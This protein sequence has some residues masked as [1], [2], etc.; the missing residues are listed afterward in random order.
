MDALYYTCPNYAHAV[1]FS[2]FRELGE[3]N[4]SRTDSFYQTIDAI[5]PMLEPRSTST[6]EWISFEKIFTMAGLC[7]TF[8]SLN[9]RDIYSDA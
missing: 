7:Y 6:S 2:R 5:A 8:N 9:S 1:L 3:I 4:I